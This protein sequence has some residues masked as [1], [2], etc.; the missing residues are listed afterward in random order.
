MT[1]K[2]RRSRLSAG[3]RGLWQRVAFA[4]LPVI[5][6]ALLLLP[7][8]QV[9]WLRVRLG[10]VFSPLQSVTP[11]DPL[12][13]EGR[14]APTA[15]SA[16]DREESLRRQ[17]V[18]YQNALVEMQAMLDRVDEQVA[19]LSHI[20]AG[21]QGLPCTLTPARFIAP[22]VAGAQSVARLAEGAGKGVRKPGAVI[23]R[24]YIDRGARE[25][26]E[27]GNPV[28][29]AAGLVGV[30]D[31]VGPMTS[32]VRLVT[33]SRL[34]I[35]VQIVAIR[36]GERRSGP[37]GMACGSGDG[38]TLVV[39]GLPRD[40]DIQPGDYIVTSPSKESPL[41]PYLVVGRV[42][43]CE[44]KPTALFRSVVAVPRVP[45]AEIRDV[46][47]LSPGTDESKQAK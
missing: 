23:A 28:L 34:N 19:D 37:E 43:S 40:S 18:A 3:R 35:M 24:Q 31:E 8:R 30:V 6:L 14:F 46:Y 41:P 12:D 21:L 22:E 38:Q 25:A 1:I 33:D 17:L 5:A 29:M 27:H 9:D 45:A 39:T 47:V 44:V 13:L 2:L 16:E 11:E 7:Q 36:S 42:K 32:T 26:I 10:P 20:R 15:G 4:S